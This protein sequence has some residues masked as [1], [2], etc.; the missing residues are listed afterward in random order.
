MNVKQRLQEFNKLQGLHKTARGLPGSVQRNKWR[1]GSGYVLSP[2]VPDPQAHGGVLSFELRLRRSWPRV[3]AQWPAVARAIDSPPAVTEQTPPR[4]DAFNPPGA[5]HASAGNPTSIEPL[6]RGRCAK[7][8]DS[9]RAILRI[10]FAERGACKS[11]PRKGGEMAHSGAELAKN[12]TQRAR[13]RFIS[14]VVKARV[15]R[16]PVETG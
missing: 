13:M 5:S 15:A 9:S 8:L 1:A 2:S 16:K 3:S 7:R 4:H 14:I 6:K 11:A 12:G 10:L